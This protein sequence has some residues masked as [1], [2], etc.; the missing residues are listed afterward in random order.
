MQRSA[1]ILQQLETSLSITPEAVAR[2]LGVGSRTVASEV[3]ALNQAL[4]GAGQVRLVGGRY[5]LR[6]YDPAAFEEARIAL[7]GV[8]ESFNDPQFR[9]AHILGQLVLSPAPVRIET[10]AR[11]MNVG[12]TTVTADLVTLRRVLAGLDVQV[13]GRPHVGLQLVGDELAIRQAV[14][15]HA[16]R[17]AYGS[18]P[19]GSAL[20]EVVEEC[21]GS[22]GF[23]ED[24]GV[25]VARWVTVCLDRHL[26][27]HPLAGPPAGHEA[28]AGS[29]AHRFAERLAE[30]VARVTGER[31]PDDEVF[32][33]A[34]PA[35]GR[36]MPTGTE[37]GG[38]MAP[39][40]TQSLVDEVLRRV[41]EGLDIEVQARD[42]AQ[43][44]THHVGF[45]LNRMR[46][47]LSVEANVDVAELA[48]RFPLAMRMA[49]I[50][51][52]V[53]HER[54]GLQMDDPELA[55]AATYFQVFLDDEQQRTRRNFRIGL[56]S[57]RGPAATSLLKGQ[58]A[59]ALTV[60]TEYVLVSSA[61]DA[62]DKRVDLVV[63][64]PGTS[65]DV[66]VPSIEL[67]EL[68][69][70]GEL[71]HR[72]SRLHFP[73]FG[74]LVGD[75]SD[76]S[77]LMLLLGPDRVVELPAGLD[78]DAAALRLADHLQRLGAVDEAFLAALRERLAATEPVVIGERLGFPHASVPG[79]AAVSCALGLLPAD[80][81]HPQRRAV[82]LMAVPE[83]ENYDDRILIRTYEEL[84]RL[85]T[86]PV[87]VDQLCAVTG[88]P[89]LFGLLDRLRD[90]TRGN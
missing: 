42:L 64:A 59:Q 36:R 26:A 2:L 29:T 80:D 77:M 83:K 35:A 10:L 86:D 21:C 13:E 67:S 23:D 8:R 47:G 70:R 85:G 60:P 5:R 65:L 12:R 1:L 22:F 16:Y 38:A 27:G 79:L 31:L 73:S 44:F 28:L 62:L 58:L 14:L 72:L 54:T 82:F 4:A 9:M 55:L 53:V 76:G 20:V 61:A 75:T 41:R 51:A 74:P 37:P 66:A 40:D 7:G 63:T 43:E 24:L 84:I 46:F 71:I 19:L 78:H 56:H 68:F 52:E 89:E 34:I 6:V 90:T 69:D 57:R 17:A 50:A 88:Y 87:L 25:V 33:L 45:M 39:Q 49:R 18:F 81:D 11:G 15:R 30:G 32:F 3:A 48:E